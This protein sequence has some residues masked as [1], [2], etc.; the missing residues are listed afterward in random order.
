[1]NVQWNR[2]M[3]ATLTQAAQTLKGHIIVHAK[4]ISLEMEKIV[5]VWILPECLPVMENY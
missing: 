3:N 2:P 5:Q 1:M 4:V